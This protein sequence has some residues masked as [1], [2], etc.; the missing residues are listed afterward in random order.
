MEVIPR[1]FVSFTGL[2][3]T[4]AGG[5]LTTFKIQER[6]YANRK[7][8]AEVRLE[9]QKYDYG[10]DEYQ[11]EN[12]EQRYL[13]FS[14]NITLIQGQEMLQEV[15]FWNPKKEEKKEERTTQISSSESEEDGEDSHNHE[16][17]KST[18]AREKPEDQ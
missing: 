10:L 4:V 5:I 14:K 2:V 3:A 16:D 11:I 7:A 8:I 1:W 12:T 9:T 15:E 18:E 13:L 6:I 17:H